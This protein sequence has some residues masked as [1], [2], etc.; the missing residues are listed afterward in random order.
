MSLAGN[1]RTRVST[2]P[3]IWSTVLEGLLHV[4]DRA[5]MSDKCSYVQSDDR[6]VV[7][8]PERRDAVRDRSGHGALDFTVGQT[9][10][11]RRLSMQSREKWSL[12]VAVERHGRE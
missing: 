2:L 9:R 5:L 1:Y 8:R 6:L 3:I 12:L 10:D 7:S 4:P 11:L